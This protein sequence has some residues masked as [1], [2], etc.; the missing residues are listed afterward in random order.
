MNEHG[1]WAWAAAAGM[2]VRLVYRDL[3]IAAYYGFDVSGSITKGSFY[4]FGESSF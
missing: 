3:S 2:K 4:V 1:S